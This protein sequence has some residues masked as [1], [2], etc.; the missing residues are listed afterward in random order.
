MKDGFVELDF[1]SF[2]EPGEYYLKIGELESK[3]FQIGLDAF[4]ATAWHTLN[5]FYAER[6][7]YDQPGIHQACHQ[8]V[9]CVHP[10]GRSLAVNGGW[11]DAADLTPRNR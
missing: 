9:T 5:F 10:D 2:E 1:S 3:P 7:G 4:L 11:H 8:D 6:C